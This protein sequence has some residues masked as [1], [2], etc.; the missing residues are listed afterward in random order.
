[1]LASWLVEETKLEPSVPASMTQ[2]D[3]PFTPMGQDQQVYF[4]GGIFFVVFFLNS[5]VLTTD[6]VRRSNLTLLYSKSESPQ[7]KVKVFEG[8]GHQL[9]DGGTSVAATT[10]GFELQPGTQC[11]KWSWV[12]KDLPSQS[13]LPGT[14]GTFQECSMAC[15]TGQLCPIKFIPCHWKKGGWN[16]E[17]SCGDLRLP[18]VPQVL[19]LSSLCD[20]LWQDSGLGAS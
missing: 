2:Q 17:A 20:L 7:Q 4:Q 10:A 15:C 13:F 18:P 8:W 1:M 11:P 3:L 12:K 5:T 6:F 19:L 16:P 9:T 14:R